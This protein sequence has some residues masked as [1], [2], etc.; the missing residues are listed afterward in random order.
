MINQNMSY[1]MLILLYSKKEI[2]KIQY[3]TNKLRHQNI[4]FWNLTFDSLTN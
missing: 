1:L 2:H 4:K 3:D